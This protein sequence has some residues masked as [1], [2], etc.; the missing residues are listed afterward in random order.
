MVNSGTCSKDTSIII[1]VSNNITINI[2]SNSPICK[3]DSATINAYGGG[4]YLWS[5]N[6][7]TSAIIVS[8]VTSTTYT[9]SISNGKCNKDTGISIMVNPLP[10]ISVIGKTPICNG[11]STTLTASGGIFYTW[12]NNATTSS[13]TISPDSTIT[14]SVSVSNG[15]CVKDSAIMIS[16]IPYPTPS[17]SGNNELCNGSSTTL[18]ASGGTNYLWSNAAT[19]SSINVNPSNTFTYTVTV[20]NG[21]CSKDTTITVTVSNN[22]TAVINAISPIC[23]GDSTT[24][25]ASGGSTYLWSNNAT[26]SAIRVNPSTSTTYT[27]SIYKGNCSKDTSILIT[28]NPIPTP[29]IYGKSPICLGDSTT[30]T[31]TGGTSYKWNNNETT[32]A[33]T[34]IPISTTTYS[35]SVSNG[36]CVKDTNILVI[37]NPLPIP[38]ITGIDSICQ[39]KSTTLTASGGG[40]YL[41][42]NSAT[43]NTII[44]TPSITTYYYIT[45]TRDSCSAR[46]SIKINVFLPPVPGISTIQPIC[47]GNQ[48]TITASG[49]TTYLWNTGATESTITVSPSANMVYTVSIINVVCTITDSTEV[50]VNP[51][52]QDTI[53]C[54]TSIIYGQQV[55]LSVTGN[56]TYSWNPIAGLSC[57][58]CPNPVAAPSASTIYS[59][60]ITNE[61]GCSETEFVKIDVSCGDVFIPNVFSPNGNTYN[62]ILYVR[63]K[64]IKSMDFVLFDRWGNKVFETIV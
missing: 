39:G 4:T 45:V 7:T 1:T 11:N 49:G 10:N 36:T 25:T 8:P 26:T 33:I 35:V 22:I 27:V 13:I 43:T 40:S 2:I 44:A 32:S 52:P 59:L 37:V 50:R 17:I 38:Y 30:L 57:S 60:T 48:V 51:V 55:Q 9:V 31:A 61:N 28:V 56:D 42:S 63:G 41:W 53:C 12:S 3:G 14:F 18:T 29:S 24:I 19:T 64:C 16:V 6:E 15:S 54:D 34:V 58:T 46:D 5:N 21:T 23:N 47:A 62:D 20:S